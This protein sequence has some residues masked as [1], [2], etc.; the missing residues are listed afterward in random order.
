MIE[1]RNISKTFKIYHKPIDILKEFIMRKPY[2][3]EYK[4]LKDISFSLDK[5]EVLGIL[6]PNGSGKSTLL[7]I[8]N[9][10][11]LPDSGEIIK[12]GKITGL[13]ELGT[14]FNYDLTGEENIYFNGML[15]GMTKEEI[16]AK[17]DDI[18]KFSELG[19]FIKEPIKIYSSGMI[20]R[21][22][23]SIAIHSNPDVFLIDEALSV[24][25]AHFQQKCYKKIKD[26]VKNGGSIIFVSHD[27]NAVKLICNKAIL[28]Y[29]GEMLDSGE[30]NKVINSYYQLLAVLNQEENQFKINPENQEYGSYEAK[31]EKIEIN[32]QKLLSGD[33]IDINIFVKAYKDIPDLSVGIL[34]R[35]RYGIDIYGIN[36]ELLGIGINM[37]E[38]ELKK[39]NF[40]L[41][42]D[43]KP[44][45]YTLTVAIHKGETHQEKCY[46]WIENAVN[47]E[48]AGYKNNRFAGITNLPIEIKID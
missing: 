10:I 23:F 14:G 48:I 5:G 8:L 1:V 20:V 7:K 12:K 11:I 13:L 32:P 36:T 24:G 47:F 3:T 30:P 29:K 37:K 42:A 41:K 26:F 25:D 2:H 40:R 46:H 38:G 18:I 19:D 27:I 45:K 15:I 34:I 17:K 35:D 33:I 44:D 28:I 43:I 4:A 21:L 22:A 31:I 9:G 6:G 16:E 39:I